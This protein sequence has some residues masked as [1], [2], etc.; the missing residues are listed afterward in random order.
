MLADDADAAGRTERLDTKRR[1][2]EVATDVESPPT[3]VGSPRRDPWRGLEPVE[4]CEDI[5][6]LDTSRHNAPLREVV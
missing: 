3:V 2:S 1:D 5:V 6:V 4:V